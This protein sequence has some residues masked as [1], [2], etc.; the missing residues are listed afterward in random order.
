M[1]TLSSDFNNA[2]ESEVERL[3]EERY[4]EYEESAEFYSRLDKAVQDELDKIVPFISYKSEGAA[5]RIY[6]SPPESEASRYVDIEQAI[7][8]AISE[9]PPEELRFVLDRL[10]AMAGKVRDALSQSDDYGE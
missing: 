2:I 3:M 9:S 1:I 5:L 4:A 6:M 7:D 8:R 10:E